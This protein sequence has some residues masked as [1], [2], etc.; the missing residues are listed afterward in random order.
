MASKFEPDVTYK[1]AWTDVHFVECCKCMATGNEL[2]LGPQT[3]AKDA[4]ACRLTR[5]GE[6]DF[7]DPLHDGEN[8][9]QGFRVGESLRQS[10]LAWLLHD[11]FV[12]DRLRFRADV[13]TRTAYADDFLRRAMHNN[14]VGR[15]EEASRAAV[16]QSLRGHADQQ[17]SLLTLRPL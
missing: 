3:G 13:L 4:G 1:A 11:L 2:V 8:L 5:A 7:E 14:A 16:D 17:Q 15:V 10:N 12:W 6:L 9:R